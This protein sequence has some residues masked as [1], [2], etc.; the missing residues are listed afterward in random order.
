MPE[1]AASLWHRFM[2]GMHQ[3]MVKVRTCLVF[4]RMSVEY[5][6]AGKYVNMFGVT[7]AANHNP[8]VVDVMFILLGVG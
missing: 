3:R 1:V 5:E 4:V 2:G 6:C 8:F 7:F